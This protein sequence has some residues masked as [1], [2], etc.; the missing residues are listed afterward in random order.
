M[1][2]QISRIS[3]S[4][5]SGTTPSPRSRKRYSPSWGRDGALSARPVLRARGKRRASPPF[6]QR[7]AIELAALGLR[8]RVGEH[9][10][11][12]RLE[13]RQHGGA[14]AQQVVGI[15]AWRRGAPPRSSPLP[16]RRSA[17]GT[18]TVAASIRSACA[19]R[20]ESISTGEILA[21]PRMMS[22]FSRPVSVR[23]PSASSAP[24]SPV[25][26]RPRLW[27]LIAA[28]L[29]QIAVGMIGKAA[30]FDVAD[31]ARRQAPAVGV[32]DGEVVI[33][34]RPA[35][36]AEAALFAGYSGDPARFA[37]P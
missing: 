18:P 37:A 26:M 17:S 23:K 13:G 24:R 9:D 25:R 28:V 36:G 31:L 12:R 35:D 1:K 7:L 6:R 19:I 5:R 11:L 4:T 20:Q 27:T 16:R 10:A 34:E 30:D 2:F 32:D 33:G 21:P 29:R 15:D 8:Q 22:S 14:I 3:N